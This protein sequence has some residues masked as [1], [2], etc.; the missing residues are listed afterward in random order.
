MLYED[1]AV[2]ALNKPAKLLAVPAD[3]SDTP[4]CTVSSFCR[5]EIE[6]ATGL[7]RTSHRSLHVWDSCSLQKPGQIETHS[8][9]SLSDTPRCGNISQ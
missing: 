8:F 7:C 4:I 5:T 1:D 9:N 2:V 3:D 6:E